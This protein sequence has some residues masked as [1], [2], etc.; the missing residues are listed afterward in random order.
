MIELQNVSAWYG[1]VIALN[2]V[3]LKIEEGVIGLLGPNGAGK[4]TLLALLSGL[5]RPNTGRVLLNGQ[6]PYDNPAALQQFGLVPEPLAPPSWL[7]GRRFVTDL[8]LLSGMS[9]TKAQRTALSALKELGLEKAQDRPIRGYSQG[10]RQ[11]VK[12]AQALVHRPKILLLDEPFTGL[13]P[14]GRRFMTDALQRLATQGTQ[15]VFSSHVLAEVEAMT[16]QVVM[17]ISGRVVAQGSV[18]DVRT[19][20]A[21]V[22]LTVGIDTPEPKKVAQQLLTLD[23]IQSVEIVEKGLHVRVEQGTRFFHDLTR[24]GARLPIESFGPVDE[25][26]ESV[27]KILVQRRAMR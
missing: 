14:M 13:D 26:L 3:E 15:V 20:M 16:N 24:L 18:R 21:S 4:S 10:M 6:P 12:L 19:Q 8:A 9:K 7:T 1:D 22:P 25:D 27:Y 23:G 2:E 17:L 11:R 5:R